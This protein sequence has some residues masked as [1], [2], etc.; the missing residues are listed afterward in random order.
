[1]PGSHPELKLMIFLSLHAVLGKKNEQKSIA[2]IA[3]HPINHISFIRLL[4]VEVI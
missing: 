2:T 1:M 3:K 4:L